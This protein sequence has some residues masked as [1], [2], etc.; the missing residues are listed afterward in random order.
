MFKGHSGTCHGRASGSFGSVTTWRLA[1]LLDRMTLAMREQFLVGRRH[2]FALV[3]PLPVPPFPSVTAHAPHPANHPRVDGLVPEAALARE[4][5][6]QVLPRALAPED[7]HHGVARAA[8]HGGDGGD[9]GHDRVNGHPWRRRA[10]ADDNKVRQPAQHEGEEDEE[11]GHGR[12]PLLPPH[13]Q[14]GRAT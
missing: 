6:A 8:E 3:S 4:D 11:A 13:Q 14:T 5:L 12:L 7:V 10:D 2:A 1:L 9:G